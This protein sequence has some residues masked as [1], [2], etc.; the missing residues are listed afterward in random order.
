MYYKIYKFTMKNSDKL[1]I[2]NFS[3]NTFKGPLF[4]C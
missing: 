1:N 4:R 3:V 2:C